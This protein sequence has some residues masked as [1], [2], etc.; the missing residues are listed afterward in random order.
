MAVAAEPSLDINPEHIPLGEPLSTTRTI[1]PMSLLWRGLDPLI[2]GDRQPS[3]ADPRFQF[4][5]FQFQLLRFHS[6]SKLSSI[7]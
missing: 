3:V 6:D 7:W 4:L 2:V 5:S 1:P